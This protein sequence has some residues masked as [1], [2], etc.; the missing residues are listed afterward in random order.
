[1]LCN[2]LSLS[3]IQVCAVFSN[4]FV[5]LLVLGIVC[6]GL[7]LFLNCAVNSGILVKLRV[8]GI[9]CVGVKEISAIC[10]MI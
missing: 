3:L 6:A 10:V 7:N 4:M 2:V 8:S 1:M 5:N 9:V